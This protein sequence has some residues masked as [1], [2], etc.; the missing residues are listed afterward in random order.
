MKKN[1]RL[2]TT[3]ESSD[4]RRLQAIW[5]KKK[6]ALQLTQEQVAAECGWTQG[7]FGHYLHGRVPLNIEAVLRLAIA[8]QVDPTEI[9]A[10]WPD[11]FESLSVLIK[12]PAR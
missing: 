12:A 6:N 1:R 4:A 11:L 5:L 8:L 10:R 9:T 3:E 7:A 2:L